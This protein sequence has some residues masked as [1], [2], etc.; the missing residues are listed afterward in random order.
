MIL[1][2]L[3]LLVV[4]NGEC[5]Y[6]NLFPESLSVNEDPPRY[7][8]A[9]MGL[10]LM[11]D[12][13][14]RFDTIEEC[15]NYCN[16]HHWCFAISNHPRPEE[17]FCQ[18]H[19][20]MSVV[21]IYE[22]HFNC[23]SV[24]VGPNHGCV[25][26]DSVLLNLDS[27]V[28]KVVNSDSF[29]FKLGEHI[30]PSRIQPYSDGFCKVLKSD[31]HSVHSNATNL[32]SEYYGTKPVS[33]GIWGNDGPPSDFAKH[34][35]NP[36]VSGFPIIGMMASTEAP[37]NNKKSSKDLVNYAMFRH[38]YS[39]Q[40][41][42]TVSVI[43]DV[44]D[45][46]SSVSSSNFF[47]I[48]QE[49]SDGTFRYLNCAV[50]G[51]NHQELNGCRWDTSPNIKWKLGEF[52]LPHIGPGS[53]F[54]T[55][56][57]Q[58]KTLI[59]Y[60][61][62]KELGWLRRNLCHDDTPWD[63]G[64]QTG[65]LP[66]GKDTTQG[67]KVHCGARSWGFVRKSAINGM[68][69]G[70]LC[71]YDYKDHTFSH[72]SIQPCFTGH[73]TPNERDWADMCSTDYGNW[74]GS[75][76]A[77]TNGHFY[78]TEYITVENVDD[79]FDG[80]LYEIHGDNGLKM[81]CDR[82]NSK[83]CTWVSN[84]E[85][86]FKFDDN[87]VTNSKVNTI[88]DHLTNRRQSM[89]VYEN[90]GGFWIHIGYVYVNKDKELHLTDNYLLG[91][92]GLELKDGVPHYG[93]ND[94]I[95]K[96]GVVGETVKVGNGNVKV[97]DPAEVHL[98]YEDKYKWFSGVDKCPDGYYLHQ[99]RCAGDSTCNKYDIACVKHNNNCKVDNSGVPNKIPFKL[100]QT[101]YCPK[102]QLA[103]GRSHT[104]LLCRPVNITAIKPEG[105]DF[106]S[107][108]PIGFFVTNSRDYTAKSLPT[109]N[110]WRGEPIQSINVVSGSIKTWTYGKNCGVNQYDSTSVIPGTVPKSTNRDNQRIFCDDPNAFI[111]F[112]KCLGDDCRTG[113]SF[114]CDTFHKCPLTGDAIKIEQK[115]STEQ[116]VCPFGTVM[117]G[118]TCI[119][120][121]I[122]Q[123]KYVPC[124]RVKIECKRVN[125]DPAAPPTPAPT[126]VD[127]SGGT[128]LKTI[129]IALG[130]GLPLLIVAAIVCLF[131]I[132]DNGPT[133]SNQSLPPVTE[134]SSARVPRWTMARR[135]TVLRPIDF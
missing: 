27:E 9:P 19:T 100:G 118:L 123:G 81:Y 53:D 129:L 49:Q 84:K 101:V 23:G 37:K 110:L 21:G 13:T 55:H 106:P 113:L 16:A 94:K 54:D 132:P 18:F 127:P 72:G 4:V 20:D 89:S 86:L 69:G 125:Y 48:K 102:G 112:L 7:I 108:P 28:F 40:K 96:G 35:N 62:G 10:A 133:L 97:G 15:E 119:Q 2:L 38:V 76:N 99:V 36:A 12:V 32:Y 26:S 51:Q 67:G 109:D 77:C 114:Y 8:K 65:L 63:S 45:K 71:M 134:S 6:D 128:S 59:A 122:D 17:H 25:L 47:Y 82:F 121:E 22:N 105:H 98:D 31:D 88:K 135:R 30:L 74:K 120:K 61:D 126:P 58:N 56:Y 33:Y 29:G 34:G 11:S 14:G 95:I 80:K 83:K 90:E 78:N 91:G 50:I 124:G 130:I 52:N 73:T 87:G 68:N 115:Q 42:C 66:G 111:T 103:V 5:F 46:Q 1:F 116:P 44:A 64:A 3:S 131:C 39:Q 79:T 104:E 41:E 24:N 75:E 117:T 107:I 60:K 57:F 85:Q 43:H 70:L 92:I 93:T